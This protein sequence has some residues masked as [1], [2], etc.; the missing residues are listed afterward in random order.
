LTPK[1]ACDADQIVARSAFTSAT[2]HDDPIDP[3]I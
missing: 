1:T 3:C 2:A